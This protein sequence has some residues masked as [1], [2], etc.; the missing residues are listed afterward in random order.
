MRQEYGYDVDPSLPQ[1]AEDYAKRE[2]ALSKLSKED[3][4][5]I[6]EERKTKLAQNLPED[7]KELS[8]E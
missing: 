6:Q 4:K 5:R 1:F 7:E 3:K 8:K 2:K